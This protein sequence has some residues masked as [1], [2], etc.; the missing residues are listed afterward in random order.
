MGQSNLLEKIL[1]SLKKI[2]P[3]KL[4]STLQPAYHYLLALGGAIIY[5]FPS[6]KIFVVAITGTKGKSSTAELVSAMLEEAGHKTAL[7]S[8]IRFKLGN[9]SYNNKFKM[10][11]PGRFFLQKFLR[12]AVREKC[13]YAIIEITSE[14]A[15]QF[16]HKFVDLNALIFTNIT[17]EHIESH[18]SFENYLAAKLKLGKAVKNSSKKRKLIVANGDDEHGKDFLNN[19]PEEKYSFSLKDAAP[20]ELQ[21][22]GMKITLEGQKINCVLSGTFNIYNVLAAATFAKTQ[23]VGIE[24]IKRTLEK[25]NG[26]RGRMEKIEVGQDFTV[27]VDY[28]HTTD[29]LE[30]VYDVFQNQKKICVL[31]GTGGGRDKWKRPEMGRIADRYCDEIILT[32]EDPYDEDPYQ[33]INDIKAGISES[34][35][36]TVIGRREAIA[37]AIGNAKTGDVVIITGKGTD[38]YIMGANGTKIPWDDATVAKEELQ[39]LITRNV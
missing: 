35:S 30:K 15:K 28:A 23:G 14:G 10:T 17:P 13:D 38:P 36:E 27:V 25:F 34:R 12:S 39:K 8:T 16:R 29:S 5:R 4:F 32:N 31:G 20:Y 3:K 6:R 21:K 1:R 37:K 2:I 24:V 11:I 18:G 22:D 26:I 9:N 19:G 7:L 33:I